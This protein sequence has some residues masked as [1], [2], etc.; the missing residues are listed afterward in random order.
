MTSSARLT[1]ATDPGTPGWPNEDF[2]AIAP[3]AAQASV[4]LAAHASAASRSPA[5]ITQN[6]PM[7]SLP[8]ANG[9]SVISLSPSWTRTTVA[10][11]GGWS[12]PAN[13]HAPADCSSALKAATSW[14]IFCAASGGGGALPSTECTLSMYCFIE[15]LLPHRTGRLPAGRPAGKDATAPRAPS[16]ADYA[17]PAASAGALAGAG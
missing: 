12:P 7:C 5:L 15:G 10:V 16:R 2:A 4:A 6:P 11:L 1:L 8:S 14:Y 17:G 13:T 9:P 3:G